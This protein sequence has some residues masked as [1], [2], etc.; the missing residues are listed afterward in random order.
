MVRKNGDR[1]GMMFLNLPIDY[2]LYCSHSG[3]T[4]RQGTRHSEIDIGYDDFFSPDRNPEGDTLSK[5]E[6]KPERLLSSILKYIC[7]YACTV[8]TII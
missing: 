4:W 2:R 6:Y 7:I 8:C 5:I 3:G 1:D